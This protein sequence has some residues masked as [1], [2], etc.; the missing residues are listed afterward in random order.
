MSFQHE[1]TAAYYKSHLQYQL[2][3]EVKERHPE[4]V[5]NA[6]ILHDYAMQTLLRMFSNNGDG[7]FPNTSIFTRPQSM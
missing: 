5:E 6:I 7:K 4:R 2:Q 3:E 1:C